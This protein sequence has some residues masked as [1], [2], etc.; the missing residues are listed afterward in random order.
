MK[1]TLVLIF[2]FSAFINFSFCQSPNITV[3]H[4]NLIS[5]FDEAPIQTSSSNK[6]SLDQFISAFTGF[7]TFFAAVI[8]AW[9]VS[10]IKKQRK[11]SYKPELIISSISVQCSKENDS[12]PFPSVW[13][14][15][16]NGHDIP[17]S[18][19]HCSMPLLNV[20]L[21]AAKNIH[22]SFKFPYLDFIKELNNIA[23]VPKLSFK[24]ESNNF[25]VMYAIDKSL[26]TYCW[27]NNNEHNF[28]IEVP[29]ANRDNNII[30]DLPIAYCQVISAYLLL[31]CV[32]DDELSN[33]LNALS[34]TSVVD[35]ISKR[36]IPP[37]QVS[38]EFYDIGDSKYS[39]KY[40]INYTRNSYK[41]NG[42]IE[43]VLQAKKSS[44]NYFFNFLCNPFFN[45][46]IIS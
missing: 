27:N 10:E 28:D 35:N 42:I 1:G 36:N 41:A 30:L 17:W 16:N 38:L 5:S 22:I 25:C 7:A 12:Y 9:M 29:L 33:N 13:K 26:K 21:G 23:S 6:L 32:S 45:W 4:G 43:G 8:S 37:L 14:P 2:I 11:A 39:S 34:D 20:G 15:I 31:T 3:K 19:Y 40:E 24:F 46:K 18:D 44:N